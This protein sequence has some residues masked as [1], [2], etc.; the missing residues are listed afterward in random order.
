[1][2]LVRPNTRQFLLRG[3]EVA[4]DLPIR[5]PLLKQDILFGPNQCNLVRR[6]LPVPLSRIGVPLQ[7]LLILPALVE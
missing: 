6:M 4:Q 5:C 2:W 7:N 1:M 3:F